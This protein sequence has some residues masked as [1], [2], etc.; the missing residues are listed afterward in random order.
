MGRKFDKT[1]K[2]V[3]VQSETVSGQLVVGSQV[4]PVSRKRG[5]GDSKSRVKQ[6]GEDGRNVIVF[7]EGIS[8]M[9]LAQLI[10][11]EKPLGL[12]FVAVFNPHVQLYVADW[13]SKE[14]LTIQKLPRFYTSVGMGIPVVNPLWLDW[15]RAGR[16]ATDFQVS[17][18]FR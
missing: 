4:S 5:Q 17:C 12:Q 16:N 11:F 9:G 18:T 13:E 1:R 3:P 8:W 14:D 2:P 15:V 7:V 10:L 6:A